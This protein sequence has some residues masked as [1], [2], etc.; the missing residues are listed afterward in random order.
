M[1]VLGINGGSAAS[2]DASAC[3]VNDLGEV[4]AFVEEERLSRVR[5]A[6]SAFPSLSVA[7]CLSLA[8]LSPGDIDV[9]AV[10][11]DEPRMSARRGNQWEYPTTEAFLTRLGLPSSGPH[12][13]D[14]VFVPHHRAH[15]ASAF[16]GS[17]FDRSAVLV[18]DGNGEDESISIYRGERGRT[19]Q[20]VSRWPRILS[21]G[22]MYEEVS[23][24]LGLGRLNAGKTMGL[25]GYGI[26]E[27]FEDPNWIVATGETLSTVLGSDASIGYDVI[28]PLWRQVISEFAG[29]GP[30]SL[31]SKDLAHDG[32]AVR[33]AWAAQTQVE[34]VVQWLACAARGMT[35]LESLCLAGGVGLNCATNGM[36]PGTVY[37]PPVPHDAGVAIGAAWTVAPPQTSAVFSPYTGGD[38]G[39]LPRSVYHSSFRVRD[40]DA[41]TV[42]K[43]LCDG[44]V[45]GFCRGRSE[46]G[47]RALGHRSLLASPVRQDMRTKV[48]LL[49]RREAWRPFGPVACEPDGLWDSSGLLERYMVGASRLS[50]K[51]K[52]AIPAVA[53]VDGTTR[54]QILGLHDEP[55]LHEI[56]Q[57]LPAA[58]HPAVLLNT[59]FNGPGEPIVETAMEAVSCAQKLGIKHLVLNDSL[60]SFR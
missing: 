10:G 9:V 59:S 29:R 36:L 28:S 42:V 43:L 23:S 39:D 7:Y 55:L 44:E 32:T 24:W 25:A 54:P 60:I 14:L 5:H 30:M 20:R 46:V 4:V 52:A 3:I 17:A 22:Y 38:P 12:L 31:D 11:W 57:T 2:H 1:Y 45:V 58:G 6:P 27:G 34:H 8:G 41:E 13:P 16:H 19:L 56:L 35:G 53:H 21:I 51:G 48:N 49:K 15:A 18:V 26:G 50:E 40:V 33:V 37:V 47:P